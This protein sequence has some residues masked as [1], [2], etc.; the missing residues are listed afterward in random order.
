MSDARCIRG[1]AC[2]RNKKRTRAYRAAEAI[3]HSPRNG[4]KAYSEL[5]L[6]TGSFATIAPEKLSLPGNLTPASGRQD[7][8]ASP[9][10]WAQLV[11]EPPSV[12]RIPHPTFVTIAKRPSYRG[13][14]PGN[15]DLIREFG[16]SESFC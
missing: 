14:T 11:F 16:K 3:R 15:I 6:A 1:L 8:T 4:F 12:H 10:A 9:Y 5:S 7:H 2:K 13:G